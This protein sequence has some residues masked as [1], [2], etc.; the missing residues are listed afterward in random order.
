[1]MIIPLVVENK[2]YAKDTVVLWKIT[3]ERICG[4][5]Y[6]NRDICQEIIT[7]PGVMFVNGDVITRSNEE[8]HAIY[9]SQRI[10]DNHEQI[11]FD[12]TW[13]VFSKKYGA[14]YE[15]FVVPQLT[16]LHIPRDLFDSL[17]VS[18]FFRHCFPNCRITFWGE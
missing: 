7:L 10:P 13:R 17:G 1:M 11:I 15:L 18:Q 4:M 5:A 6:E 14:P 12:A 2:Y 8:E 16:R 3:W 9:Y